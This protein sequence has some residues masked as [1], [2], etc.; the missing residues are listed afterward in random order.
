MEIGCEANGFGLA[1]NVGRFLVG[2][3]TFQFR[4]LF[5]RDRSGEAIGNQRFQGDPDLEGVT[6][7]FDRRGRDD[8]FAVSPQ[9]DK[10]FRCQPA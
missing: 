9:A 1:G 6:G 10:T 4:D 8:G 3:V 2:D 7:L 5:R